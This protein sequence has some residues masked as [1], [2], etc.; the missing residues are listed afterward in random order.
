MAQQSPISP[1]SR[2][3]K[4][5]LPSLL[6]NLRNAHSAI[7]TSVVGTSEARPLVSGTVSTNSG[8]SSNTYTADRSSMKRSVTASLSSSNRAPSALFDTAPNIRLNTNPGPTSL[9]SALTNFQQRYENTWRKRNQHLHKED[10]SLMHNTKRR[11]QIRVSIPQ[12]FLLS[13]L[14]FFIA[15][16]LL[17]LLYVLARKSVFGDEG[18]DLSEHKYEVK[19]FDGEMTVGN[20]QTVLEELE[21]QFKDVKVDAVAQAGEVGSDSI[22][23]NQ[24]ELHELKLDGVSGNTNVLD[25]SQDGQQDSDISNQPDKNLRGYQAPGIDESKAETIISAKSMEDES[26]PKIDSSGNMLV[27]SEQNSIVDKSDADNIDHSVSD[28]DST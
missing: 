22:E 7:A 1:D 25:S 14:C 16:P 21:N 10:D 27:E 17:V 3:K 26:D 28:K 6:S 4:P 5:A 2:K 15:I 11:R 12:A 18:V 8:Q 24:E 9:S 19:T 23:M 20:Q 13:S